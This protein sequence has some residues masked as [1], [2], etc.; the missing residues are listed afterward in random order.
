MHQSS[1]DKEVQQRKQWQLAQPSSLV[2]LLPS[3]QCLYT[4]VIC[5]QRRSK[6]VCCWHGCLGVVSNNRVL[7]T[8]RTPF[9]SVCM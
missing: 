9:D 7:T 6:C 2:M 3:N 8:W 4:P 5:R 1:R